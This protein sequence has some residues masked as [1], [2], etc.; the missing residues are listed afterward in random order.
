MSVTEAEKAV[1]ESTCNFYEGRIQEKSL[2][3]P[4][5]DRHYKGRECLTDSSKHV[6]FVIVKSKSNLRFIDKFT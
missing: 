4:N 2:M 3:M 1:S 6:V 5:R